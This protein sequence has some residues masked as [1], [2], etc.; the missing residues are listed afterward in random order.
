MIVA[1]KEKKMVAS[2]ARKEK[3]KK[4]DGNCIEHRALYYF[5]TGAPKSSAPKSESK[6]G[7]PKSGA[8]KLESKSGA[9]S[10][11]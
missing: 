5:K 4:S 1:D 9:P 8:P 10:Y 3:W 11:T 6:S 7:A 2:V